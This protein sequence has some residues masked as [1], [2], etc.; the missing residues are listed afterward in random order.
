MNFFEK[1]DSKASFSLGLLGGLG[2]MFAVGFFILLGIMMKGEGSNIFAPTNT[3]QAVAAPTAPT[4]TPA[5]PTPTGQPPAVSASDHAIG[6]E[7]AKVT[8]IEFSDIQCPYCSRFHP[9][10]K[11]LLTE[12]PNDIRWVYKHF[13]L[14]S[15]HP[16]AQSAA[17]ASECLA[18]QKGDDGFFAY[19]DALF[20]QQDSLGRDLYVTEAT[21]LGANEAQFTDCID[22]GKYK[23]RVSADYQQGLQ[24]GITGTPGSF[25]N[26]QVVRGALP[27]EQVKVMVDAELAQ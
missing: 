27:Y 11:Q 8:L 21:K 16:M 7:N 26:T 3:N 22:S 1:M 9:T 23:S 18:E 2:V 19:L 14:S 20:A 6:P 25:I 10:V 13:P 5:E 24:A 4:P 15:I 17:E 12:Y